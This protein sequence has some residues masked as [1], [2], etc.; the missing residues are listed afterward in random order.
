MAELRKIEEAQGVQGVAEVDPRTRVVEETTAFMLQTINSLRRRLTPTQVNWIRES[1]LLDGVKCSE[2]VAQIYPPVKISTIWAL[3][4]GRTYLDVP[5]TRRLKLA[6][7]SSLKKRQ[8][9]APLPNALRDATDQERED[10]NP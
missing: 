9:P 8:V 3:V 1:V 4:R 2:I 5:L 10:E 6:F 7:R